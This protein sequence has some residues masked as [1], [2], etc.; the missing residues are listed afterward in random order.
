MPNRFT[1]AKATANARARQSSTARLRDAAP[2]DSVPAASMTAEINWTT[3]ACGSSG[4]NSSPAAASSV[5]A[6]RTVAGAL[7]TVSHSLRAGTS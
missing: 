5:P 7:H 1:T 4:G 2:F 6:I 3:A